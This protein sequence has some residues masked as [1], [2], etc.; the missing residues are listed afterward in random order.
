MPKEYVELFTALQ[1][2]VE[3]QPGHEIKDIVS[4]SLY[5]EHGLDFDEVFETFE[6]KPLGSASIGQVHLAILTDSFLK[7]IRNGSKDD[8]VSYSG[9]GKVA[10]KCMNFDAEGE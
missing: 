1:D 9:D 4:K 6:D 10:V 3:G 2:S 8:S 7:K 5:R